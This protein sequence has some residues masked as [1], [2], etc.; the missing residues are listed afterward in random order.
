MAMIPVSVLKP[1]A[2]AKYPTT[3]DSCVDVQA[4]PIHVYVRAC[5]FALA[6]VKVCLRV[7]SSHIPLR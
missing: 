5:G 2:A 3:K 6:F 7:S 4:L 1:P